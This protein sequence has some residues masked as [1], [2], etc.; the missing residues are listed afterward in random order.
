MNA[1]RN[2]ER[3]VMSRLSVIGGS[4]TFRETDPDRIGEGRSGPL[5]GRLLGGRWRLGEL[6]GRGGMSS[7]YAATHRNGKQVAIKV[8]RPDLSTR[9]RTKWRFLREG[10]IANRIHHDGVVT[11]LDDFTQNGVVFLVMDL[12]EGITV[13]QHC[14]ERGG[15]LGVGEVL[16]IADAVLDVLIAAHAVGVVHRDIKPSNLFLTT[17]PTLKLLDFGI[18]SL[19]ETPGVT[20][21]TMNGALLGTPG[22][23]APE[24]ARGRWKEVDARTDLWGV[25]AL[26]FRLLTGRHVHEGESAHETVVVAAT[27]SASSLASIDAS[28]SAGL[29]ALVDRA[30]ESDAGARWQ[31][32]TEMQNAVRAE[33]QRMPSSRLPRPSS[34]LT[35]ATLDEAM[36]VAGTA[37]ELPARSEN[38]ASA[39]STRPARWWPSFVYGALVAVVFLWIVTGQSERT[40]PSTAPSRPVIA[41]T[42][43]QSKSELP[44]SA[45]VHPLVPAPPMFSAATPP[46]TRLGPKPAQNAPNASPTTLTLRTEKRNP[47]A[48]TAIVEPAASA[49]AP[50]NPRR[51]EDVLDERK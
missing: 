31:S 7:V 3:R 35:V 32:A 12:L 46:A 26:M 8:L 38:A 9:E 34:R 23:M 18:A 48:P 5:T 25:G 2:V 16:A 15:I 37:N 44:L 39:R 4:M 42:L 13:E 20:T 1:A 10:H 36:S 14:S 30:L 51:L 27:K 43:S 22:F 45:P 19:R 29:V 49:P 21:A 28:L 11:V 24:Q 6:L 47:K 50:A 33:R 17:H 40:P 41:S